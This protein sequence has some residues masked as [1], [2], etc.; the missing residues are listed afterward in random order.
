MLEALGGRFTDKEGREICRGAIGLKDLYSADLSGLLGKGL[1]ITVAC[2]VTN[3]LCGENGASLIYGPQK[4]ATREMAEEMDGWLRSFALITECDPY[5]EGTGAA[6]GMSFALKN[7]LDARMMSGADIVMEIT[8]ANSL[9]SDC[10]VVV[11]GEGRMDLQT[12]NGKA[13]YKI[14][15]AGK[16]FGKTVL[17]ITGILGEG[18]EACIDAGFNSVTPLISPSMER[19]KALESVELTAAS[20]FEKLIGG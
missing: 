20:V 7:F 2:D 18:Y 1:D 13:P 14:L 17:G 15:L 4:G 12:V 6:G 11:T 8:G 9:I 19:E 3:P 16:H 10:D 5:E